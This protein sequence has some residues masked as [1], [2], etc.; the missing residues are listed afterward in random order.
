MERKS[1]L[2]ILNRELSFDVE[3][4]AEA[5]GEE[6]EG[7]ND[8]HDGQ[9]GEEGQVGVVKENIAIVL[10]DHHA[11]GGHGGLDADAEEA[12]ARLDEDGGGEIGGDE[13]G[14]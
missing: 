4:V 12:Q 5:V 2:K 11:P 9:A 10:L 6:H 1:F 13:T 8:E 3:G 14:H 7:E